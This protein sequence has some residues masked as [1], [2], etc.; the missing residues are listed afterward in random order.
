MGFLYAGSENFIEKQRGRSDLANSAMAGMF[1]G[2]VL[3]VMNIGRWCGC[4]L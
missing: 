3:A 1:T 4:C 2:G